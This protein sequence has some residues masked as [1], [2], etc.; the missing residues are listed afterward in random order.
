MKIRTI[1]RF[2]VVG[3]FA[4]L[5]GGAYAGNKIFKY[6]HWANFPC[7]FTTFILCLFFAL[8]AGAFLFGDAPKDEQANEDKKE[9][10]Q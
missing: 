4:S 1:G 9:G 7:I 2:A 8:V 10:D 6:P 5:W 3:F